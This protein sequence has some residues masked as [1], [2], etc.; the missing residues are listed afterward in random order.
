MADEQLDIIRGTS[1]RGGSAIENAERTAE[2]RRQA[3]LVNKNRIEAAD[4][5]R[6]EIVSDQSINALGS[7]E[8]QQTGR[9]NRQLQ[10]NEDLDQSQIAVMEKRVWS[11]N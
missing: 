5:V 6:E 10:R 11:T 3:S 8:D 2:I 9:V 7:A 1:P 4:Q